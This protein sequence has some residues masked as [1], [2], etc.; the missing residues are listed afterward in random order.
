[1]YVNQRTLDRQGNNNIQMVD[2]LLVCQM[3]QIIFSC[4]K[5]HQK[6]AVI[7][8]DVQYKNIQG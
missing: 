2:I 3:V 1:M 7:S 4:R 5:E 8:P 6:M